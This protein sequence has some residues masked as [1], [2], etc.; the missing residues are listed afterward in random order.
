MKSDSNGKLILICAL[1]QL[2]FVVFSI[3]IAHILIVHALRHGWNRNG[4]PPIVGLI[5]NHN[6]LLLAIPAVWGVPAILSD[7]RQEAGFKTRLI[8]F[9]TGILLVFALICLAGGAAVAVGFI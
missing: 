2:C 8:V 1:S 9:V 5:E 7:A 4:M 3:C 6:L